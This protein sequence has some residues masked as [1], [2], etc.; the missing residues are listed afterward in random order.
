MRGR[1]DCLHDWTGIHIDTF[2]EGPVNFDAVDGQA[3][4]VRQT[5]K[6]GSEIVERDADP[7][8]AQL[9]QRR[10]DCR[11]ISGEQA[12]RKLELQTLRGETGVS[13]S[14][15]NVENEGIGLDLGSRYIDG[16]RR[17]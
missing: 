9:S 5:R 3:S 8:P 13:Q 17:R 6:S 16:N 11:V 2:N 7:G 14:G 1:Q 4:Q 12:L 10:S 15:E